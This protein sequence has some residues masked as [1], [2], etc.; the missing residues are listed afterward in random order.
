MEETKYIMWSDGVVT[1]FGEL[2]AKDATT[3]TVK[4][5]VIVMFQVVNEPVF[6][7]KGEVKLDDNGQPIMRGGLKWDMNPYVFGVC[8]KNADDNVWTVSPT[9][10]I[11]EDAEYD[12]RLIGHYQTLIKLCGNVNA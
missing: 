5:P 10:I 7:E 11:C 3:I 9:S 12:E 8:I 1:S 6:D 4:N 2:V